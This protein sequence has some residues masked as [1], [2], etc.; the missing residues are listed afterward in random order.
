[1][2]VVFLDNLIKSGPNIQIRCNTSS[3]HLHETLKDECCPPLLVLKLTGGGSIDLT[4]AVQFTKCF[5]EGSIFNAH[6]IARSHLSS[7]CNTA[8]RCTEKLSI[9]KSIN[10]RDN[11]FNK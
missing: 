6:S 7:R 5:I 3:D 1:M 2:Q 9:N 10:T 11:F 8:I 4:N